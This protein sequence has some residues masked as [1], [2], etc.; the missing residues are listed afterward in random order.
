[1]LETKQKG[2]LTELQCLEA[3]SQYGFNVSIP[4]GENSRYDFI[5]DINGH[6]LRI[7]VKTSH[8]FVNEDNIIQ[9]FEFSTRS[10]RVNANGTYS[11]GYNLDEIDYFTTYWDKKCYLVPVEQCCSATKKL[12]LFPPKNN[13]SSCCFAEDY[14][15]EKQL[16][17]YTD[18][19]EFLQIE[20]NCL[21]RHIIIKKPDCE[22]IK[23]KKPIFKNKTG[24]CQS[25][26]KEAQSAH[27]PSREELKEQIYNQSFLQIGKQYGVSD[28]AVRKWCKKYNLPF[29]KSVIKNISQEKWAS[30]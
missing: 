7:Q 1:M 3:F 25:C 18:E 13:C 8:G 15:I 5:A 24:L 6:L 20:D 10:T 4:Y 21:N 26:Y 16:S 9:S 29:Q 23:C 30:I 12:W 27:I 2:I 14:S 19:F 28:N 11:H 22:C 17:D